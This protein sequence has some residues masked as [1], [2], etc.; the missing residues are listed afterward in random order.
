MALK[1]YNQEDTIRLMNAWSR[2]S[3]PFLFIV[4]YSMDQNILIPLDEVDASEI[5]YDFEGRSNIFSPVIRSTEHEIHFSRNP[6][7]FSDFEKSFH[8]VMYGLHRGD[9]FLC[10]L[11][12]ETPVFCS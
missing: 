6:I 9:S 3:R 11:T 1:F 2:E 10:N 7:S 5:K 4:S 8:R 12:C